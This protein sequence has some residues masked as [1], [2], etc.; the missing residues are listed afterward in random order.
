MRACCSVESGQRS[1]RELQPAL[2]HVGFEDEPCEEALESGR[3]E[4]RDGIAVEPDRH[5]PEQPDLQQPG[6]GIDPVDR[7]EVPRLGKAPQRGLTAVVE[8]DLGRADEL[9]DHAR[10]EDLVTLRLRDDASRG[11]DR[12][13]TRVAVELADVAGVDADAQSQVE[14]AFNR[15]SAG[16][17][18]LDLDGRG[19]RGAGRDEHRETPVAHALDDDTVVLGN[20]TVDDFVVQP[21]LGITGVVAATGA[22]RSRAHDVREEHGSRQL[23]Q[24]DSPHIGPIVITTRILTASFQTTDGAAAESLAPHPVSE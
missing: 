18:A 7:I 17:V 24:P 13:T 19:H 9:S 4:P 16:E 6:V 10:D 23:I 20:R 11:I 21:K 14:R 8:G 22:E 3:I 5:L 2:G 1:K 15:S 12:F